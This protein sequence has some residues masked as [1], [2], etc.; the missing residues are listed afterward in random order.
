MEA[1]HR[2]VLPF[3]LRRMKEDVLQDLPPKIIQDYYC[4]LSPLQVCEYHLDIWHNY[5]TLPESKIASVGQ[6]YLPYLSFV[7]TQPCSFN[8]M[9]ILQRRK[10]NKTWKI[11]WQMMA[12]GKR[13]RRDHRMSSRLFSTCEKFVIILRWSW[14]H[15]IPNMNASLRS[16]SYNVHLFMTSI[17]PVNW[18]L[19]G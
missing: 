8:C 18:L 17:T 13:R 9:K 1:L 2:Q 12:M 19:W 16:W 6:I 3:L 7:F 4:E 14:L 10:Q 15:H 5:A 11:V